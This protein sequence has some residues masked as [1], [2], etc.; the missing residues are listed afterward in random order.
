MHYMLDT[1]VLVKQDYV[2]INNFIGMVYTKT[3]LFIVLM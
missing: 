1:M 3:Y 2:S